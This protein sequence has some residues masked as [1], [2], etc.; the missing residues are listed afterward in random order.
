MT[1]AS[2]LRGTSHIQHGLALSEVRG[3]VGQQLRVE[4]D[5][6][7]ETRHAVCVI[8]AAFGKLTADAGGVEARGYQ[9]DSTF[10]RATVAVDMENMDKWVPCHDAKRGRSIGSFLVAVSL[11]VNLQ[12]QTH[13]DDQEEK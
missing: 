7:Q 6:G 5:F 8:F 12:R 10:S 4:G 1:A 3:A 2:V 13:G 9:S 11:N